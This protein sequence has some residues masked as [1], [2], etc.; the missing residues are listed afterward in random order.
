MADD[1]LTDKGQI[2]ARMA[3]SRRAF[4]SALSGADR[5]R[6]DQPGTWGEWSVKDMI[7]H[8]TY[9]QTLATERLQKFAAGRGNE[10]VS[11]ETGEVD[12]INAHVYRANK[13]RPLDEMLNAC[14]I[15]YLTLRTA[16]K[17][18]PPAVYTE[19]QQPRSMREI[20]AGNSYLHYEEHLPDVQSLELER[21]V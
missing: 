19:D 7:A 9:W 14:E 8:L 21:E 15:A 20:I 17:Q 10:I 13:E 3:E 2:L 6:L 16:V 4:Q 5:T 11:L 1:I 18:L 12:A